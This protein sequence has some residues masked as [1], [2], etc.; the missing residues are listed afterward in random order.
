VE[1]N[2]VLL[3]PWL[4][5]DVAELVR[6][7]NNRR[8]WA[9]LR[10]A[11]PHPYTEDAGRAWVA[12]ANGQSPVTS[13]AIEHC[14]ALAGGIGYIPGKDVERC[15]AEVGYWIGEPY[16]G[17]GLATAALLALTG[18]VARRGGFT[19]LFALPFATNRASR[20]VLEKA[21]FTLDAVL[22]RSA[23][24]E[25]VVVDQCLYSF[26]LSEESVGARRPDDGLARGEM[27]KV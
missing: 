19:R 20:R 10:D 5:D 17:R 15:S 4:D 27:D 23:V 6:L 1:T 13:L 24:K 18:V 12:F 26:L 21:G 11:F 25:G 7:A 2:P 9:Q 22:R 8:I 16:W 3:R 14:G